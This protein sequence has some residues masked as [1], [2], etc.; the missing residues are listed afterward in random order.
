M[1][2]LG[3][4]AIFADAIAAQAVHDHGALELALAGRHRRIP[5]LGPFLRG[6]AAVADLEG[7]AADGA[8]AFHLNGV[9]RGIGSPAAA[10][11]RLGH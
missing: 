3:L 6:G 7:A 10:D 2:W 8:A 5:P 9:R 1:G 11:L 4:L